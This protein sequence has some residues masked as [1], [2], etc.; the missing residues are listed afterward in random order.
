MAGEGK[1]IGIEATHEE[2]LAMMIIAR[3]NAIDGRLNAIEDRMKQLGRI[4][5][6]V[7]AALKAVATESKNAAD[8]R[9]LKRRIESL[10]ERV[11][12]G[13]PPL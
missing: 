7:E 5:D 9:E 4:A 6:L 13:L 3:L 2:A 10:E 8:I 1:P 12:S 11:P